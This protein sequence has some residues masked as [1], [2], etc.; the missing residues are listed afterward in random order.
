MN[1][2]AR[3]MREQIIQMQQWFA[4]LPEAVKRQP[5]VENAVNK[6]YQAR[7]ALERLM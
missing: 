1:E 5:D 4:G 6:L 3:S 2:V 7:A